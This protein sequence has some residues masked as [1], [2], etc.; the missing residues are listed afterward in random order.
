VGVTDLFAAKGPSPLADRMR[1]RT[2]EELVGQEEAVAALSRSAARPPS[3]IFWGPPGCGKTTLARLAAER[4]GLHF[5]QF[6][7]VTSGIKEVKEAIDQARWRRA[8]EKKGTLLFVD[9]IHRFNRA[10][11]DAFL[12]AIEDGTITLFGATT[13]NPSFE[14]NA[15]LLSRCR[16]LTLKPLTLDQVKT[17][18]DRAAKREK[19]KADPD[20]LDA[21]AGLAGGDARAAL[22]ILEICGKRVTVKTVRE[23]VQR[24][25]L[26]Y[27][28]DRDR[29]YDTIS[30]F[31]KSIRGSDVDAALYWLARMLESGEDPLFIARRIVILASEDVGNADPRGIMVAVAAKEAVDFIGMPEGFLPLAQAVTYLATAPKSNASYAAYLSAL[32]DVRRLPNEPVPLHL[33]NAVTGLMKAE[34]Y[35]QGYEYAHDQPGAVVSHGHRPANVEGRIYY[36]PI[37]RGYEVTIKKMMEERRKR[38]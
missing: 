3:V 19:L 23:A 14:V 10:Q 12:H 9:E 31:I 29:H 1:P 7:A 5:L 4:S 11:Q 2:L 17:I 35:G 30:A 32:E 20:A 21:I 33:R 36:K 13:E 16:V 15:P 25:T 27:D 34:G 26:A 37:D 28:K 6:S 8:N 22:N 24:R 38:P 18:L